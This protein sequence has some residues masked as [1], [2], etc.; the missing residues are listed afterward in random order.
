MLGIL[1]T[2]YAGAE[3][4]HHGLRDHEGLAEGVVEPYRDIARELY[5]LLL[6]FAH[7]D[8][9]RAVDQDIRRHQHGIG[10]EAG[11]Y[12]IRVLCGFI[13]ELGHAGKLAHVCG[14][15][16]QPRKLRVLVNVA[17]DEERAPFGID[18]AGDEQRRHRAGLLP[19]FVGIVPHRKRVHIRDHIIAVFII[20]LHELPVA[21]SPD[22]V[23]ERWNARR[24]DAA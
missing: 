21:E 24:L 1:Q 10:E 11:V 4:G 3:F 8:L 2:H 15:A 14:A 5:V 17:L 16:K 20:L 12:V 6:I 19:Q 7:G 22:V 18:A 23:A 9:M 13:L